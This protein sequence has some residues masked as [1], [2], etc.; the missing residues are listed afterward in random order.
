MSISSHKTTVL[1]IV[2]LLLVFTSCMSNRKALNQW[3]GANQNELIEKWGR[4]DRIEQDG[5]NAVW[6]YERFQDKFPGTTGTKSAAFGEEQSDYDRA[7]AVKF[8]IG[9]N[10]SVARYELVTD[11][12]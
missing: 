5:L 8:I 3:I 9:P 11:D 2:S 6:I 1:L 4:P 10:R 12:D 7:K